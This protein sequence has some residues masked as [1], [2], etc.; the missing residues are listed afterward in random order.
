MKAFLAFLFLASLGPV[1]AAAEASRPN[2]ILILADDL[3]YA[4]VG[5]NGCT[6]IKTPALDQLAETGIVCTTAYVAHPVCGPSRAAIMTGRYPHKFGAQCNIPPHHPEMGITKDETFIAQVLKDAGYTTALFGKW[7]L[8]SAPDYL[9]NQR[10]FDEF[11]GIPG[12]GHK[13][14]PEHYEALYNKVVAAGKE[15]IEENISPLIRNGEEAKETEYL[16]DAF[17]REAVD[18]VRKASLREKPFFLFLSYNAPHSPLEAKEDDLE[19]YASIK[20]PARKKYAAMVH[21]VDRG[22]GEL[23]DELKATGEYE[24]SLIVFLSDNGG[25]SG[26]TADNGPLRG[27]KRSVTEGGY[28]VPMFFHWPEKITHGSKFSH[29]VLALDLYPTF[30]ALAGGK[31]PQGKHLDGKNIW[32]NL[33]DGSNPHGNEMIPVMSHWLGKTATAGRFNEWKVT[34][35]AGKPWKLY[36]IEEDIGESNDLSSQYPERL[37]ELVGGVKKW[38]DSHQKP[39]WHYNQSDMDLWKNVDGPYIEGTFDLKH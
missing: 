35:E 7:H 6:D 30:T 13:Y 20:N 23:I 4:D 31:I 22:V 12:S 34:R 16:T 25:K 33:L 14:F 18:F 11:F 5:F 21:A 9:P 10:G 24:N 39:L 27:G 37:E 32:Q 26:N 3:G 29:P 15:N 28:R 17:S 19:K 8:G 2:I 1:S 38:A 36:N